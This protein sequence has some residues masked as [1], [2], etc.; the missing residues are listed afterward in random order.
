M[1]RSDL[2][3]TFPRRAKLNWP[4]PLRAIRQLR[5]DVGP[6]HTLFVHLTLVPYM[7]AAG[8]LKTKPTQHSVRELMEIGIMPDIQICRTEHELTEELR[9]KIALFCNVKTEAVIE[10]ANGTERKK[11]SST[12]GSRRRGS[13]HSSPAS[14][15]AANALS[16]LCRPAIRSASRQ[17]TRP[18][19]S[20]SNR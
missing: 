20:R 5:S 17:R 2:C 6:E 9:R 4:H 3:R 10:A 16:M 14:A 18:R 8:E 1:P 12:S 19:C 7:A 15:A 13:Y 11:R